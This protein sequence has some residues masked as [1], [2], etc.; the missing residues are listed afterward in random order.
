MKFAITQDVLFQ[1]LQKIAGVVPTKSTT[2]ILENIFFELSK[3]HLSITGTDLE[4]SVTTKVSPVQIEETGAFAL[5]ARQI[6]ETVRSLPNV[7]IRFESDSNN[8]V[9]MITDQ[10]GLYQVSGISKDNFP[11]LPSYKENRFVEINNTSLTRM[12]NKTL[13]AV[14]TDELRPALMGVFVQ[15]MPNELRM[16]ATDGHRLSIIVD[17]SFRCDESSIRMIV[18]P[19][20]VQII[21]KNL[22]ESGTTKLIYNEKMMCLAFDNTI[23]FTR[24]VEGQYP[25]YERVIPKDNDKK[26][27]VEKNLLMTSVK[28]VGLYSSMLTHQIRFQLDQGKLVILSEDLDIGGE[29]REELKVEF[30][31]QAMEIGYN[32]MYLLDILKQVDTDDVVFHLKTPMSAALLSP[33]TQKEGEAFQ[34]LI[35][36]IKLGT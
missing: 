4:V 23:L 10:G 31:A 28:R 6:I 32:S 27:I 20:A 36:P 2:P 14:S 3:S 16:V 11:E 1:G 24:I 15:I 12:F 34:L 30:N 33:S 19:K 18:P 21:L 8:R 26:L 22:G 29:A 25:D 35:M 13:F 9:K 7:Q 17:T 5:P